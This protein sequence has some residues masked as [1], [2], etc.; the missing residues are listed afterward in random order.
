MTPVMDYV[1]EIAARFDSAIESRNNKAIMKQ[2]SWA[3]KECETVSGFNKA[4]YHYYIATAYGAIEPRG[5]VDADKYTRKQMLHYRLSVDAFDAVAEIDRDT[6]YYLLNSMMLTNYANLLRNCGRFIAAIQKYRQAV[7]C[8][9]EA[10]MALGNLGIQ[11]NYYGRVA[12]NRNDSVYFHKMAYDALQLSV[13]LDDPNVYDKAKILFEQYLTAYSETPVAQMQL[14][15]ETEEKSASMTKT[16]YRYRKWALQNN[17]FLNELNDTPLEWLWIAEDD[18]H[19]GPITEDTVNPPVYFSMFNQIKQEYA[20]ARYLIHEAFLMK[21]RKQP[22][23]ADKKI[24]LTYSLDYAC[25][26][27]RLEHLKSAF[28]TL[29]NLFDRIA[30]LLNAYFKIGIRPEDVSFSSIWN[31]HRG[32]PDTTGYVYSNPLNLQSNYALQA[33]HWMFYDMECQTDASNPHL[34]RMRDIRHALTH[35]YTKV[36][37]EGIVSLEGAATLDEVAFHVTDEELETLTMELIA[38]LRE[39]IMY[40]VFSIRI[41]EDKKREA[42][43]NRTIIQ[44]PIDEYCDE[45]KK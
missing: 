24:H 40:A 43:P 27:M 21:E 45:W 34:P 33:L 17:L 5:S 31:K 12:I 26:S 13:T 10:G 39:A 11:Y 22:Y 35:R 8:W 18:I 19:I 25:Y 32:N 36:I 30:F 1:N 37:T 42:E 7:S 4:A 14:C 41:E 9:P 2:I 3:K 20:Y 28:T 23:Y 29:F 16:E 38:S 15:L 44:L 6:D